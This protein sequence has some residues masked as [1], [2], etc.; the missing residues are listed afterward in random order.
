MLGHIAT[1]A[2]VRLH[3]DIYGWMY[4]LMLC[5]QYTSIVTYH[6]ATHSVSTSHIHPKKLHS[7][8]KPFVLLCIILHVLY[9]LYK[10]GFKTYSRS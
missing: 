3:I 9:P 2:H 7:H 10:F 1:G 6:I 8:R 5:M 4:A